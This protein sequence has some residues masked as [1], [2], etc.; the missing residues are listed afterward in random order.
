MELR[1]VIGRRRSIRF[2]RPYMPVEPEKIQMMFEAARIATHWGNVQSL[3]AVAIHRH[4]APQEV[5]DALK[6]VV[7][8]WQLRIAPVVIVWYCD[9]EQVEEQGNRLRQLMDVG[10]LGFG[11]AEL[12]R[13]TLEEKFI[14][15]FKEIKDFLKAPGLNEIDC[16]QGMAQATLMAYELGLGSCFLGTPDGDSILKVLGV[17]SHCRLLLMQCVGYPME[18]WEAGGQ[19]PRQPFESLFSLNTYGNPYPRSQA[20]VDE[21]TRDKM[22]TR[23]APLP[24]REAELEYLERALKLKAPGLF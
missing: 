19:R 21:L 7:V 3:R 9:P 24:E 14:P 11:P 13:N 12:K 15:A 18:H 22:F 17:P 4:S 6:A 10:A 2:L 20:V 1:E 8:G 16:G 5:L 23:P